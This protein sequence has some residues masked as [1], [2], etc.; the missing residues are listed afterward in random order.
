MPRDERQMAGWMCCF[1]NESIQQRQA[2]PV[3]LDIPLEDEGTPTLAAHLAC[4]RGALH[5]SVP[6][7]VFEDQDDLDES[8]GGVAQTE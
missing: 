4:L 2:D 6:L 3:F 8:R 5:P 7:G 1:C